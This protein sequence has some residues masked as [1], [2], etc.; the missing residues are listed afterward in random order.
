MSTPKSWVQADATPGTPRMRLFCL[1]HAGGGASFY[2]GWQMHMPQDVQVCRIQPPGRENRIGE[3]AYRHM[4]VLVAELA[5][6]LQPWLDQ[7]FALFG[8]SMGSVVAYELA[9]ALQRAGSAPAHLWVSACRAPHIADTRQIHHLPQ[10]EFF[11]ALGARGGTPGSVLNNSDYMAMMEPV[12]RADLA[13]IERWHRTTWQP[14]PCP[15]TAL[16]AT[17]DGVTP[18][19]AVEAWRP[20]THARFEL[21]RFTGG[22]FYLSDPAL[23]V[24]ALVGRALA[25]HMNQ[26]S[27]A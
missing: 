24:P 9:C 23:S 25:A 10:A 26:E 22:H 12:L 2:R 21:H 16:A 19:D 27:I 6:Q 11:A 20:Y 15:V 7:P 3:L 5:A 8:H 18:L 1:P 13:L 14:L 4:T 17:D